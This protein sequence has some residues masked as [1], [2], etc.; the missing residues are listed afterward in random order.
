MTAASAALA[1]GAAPALADQ[2]KVEPGVR[3]TITYSDNLSLA[4]P[5][6]EESGMALGLTPRIG[7]TG[8]GPRYS[9][10]ADYALSGYFYTNGTLS[11]QFY[12]NLNLFG[13]VE[14][15]E[16]FFYVDGGVN[17]FQNFLSPL[18]PITVSP[19]LNTN[20]RYTTYVYRLNPYLKGQLRGDTNY[21]LRW[22]NTWVDYSQSGM[23]ESYVSD[24]IGQLG[25]PSGL[26]RRVGW[27]LDYNRNYVKYNQQEGFTRELVRGI[28]Y[29]QATP[30]LQVSGRA[31]YENNDYALTRYSGSIYG[32]GVDWRPTDRTSVNGY[33]EH[34]FFGSS[35]AANLQHRH[36]MLGFRLSGSRAV[37]TS[38]QQYNLGTG[39][40]YDVVDAAFMSR[41][42]DPAQRQQAV[43]QFLQQTGLPPIL[44]QPIYFYNNQIL[45]QERIEA[46]I[47][48]NGAR[49]SVVLTVYLSDQAPIT[50]TGTP[51]DIL[52]AN[53]QNFVQRGASASYTYKLSGNQNISMLALRYHTKYRSTLI[54]GETDYTIF[55]AL[56]TSNL[57]RRTSWFAGAR[58]QWQDPNNSAF[59]QYR[60]AAVFGGIDYTYR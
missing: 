22:N 10:N 30:E 11:N 52:L 47:S 31:G 57:S 2:W 1:I 25:Q 43:L 33:W 26:E 54:P 24:I 16:R 58:Y 6:K 17:I 51:I 56:F 39:L 23:R 27:G 34:R 46:A 18:G 3:G 59:A 41:I 50:A 60:E 38:A 36:R 32:A 28:L 53:N 40:A 19:E 49:N 12:S 7:I 8:R 29:Y 15:I 42:P 21:L 13:N 9:V 48:L 20:N 5:G 35:Y 37:T 4:P 14:A 55:R 44:T 45:L